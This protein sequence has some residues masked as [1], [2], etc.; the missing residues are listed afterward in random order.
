MKKQI[1]HNFVYEPITFFEN[2]R[3]Y[4]FKEALREDW[5]MTK[6]DIGNTLDAVRDTIENSLIA[7]ACIPVVIYGSAKMIMDVDR[8]VLSRSKS[9]KLETL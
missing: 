3:K 9:Q 7:L 4:G 6:T 8:H 2:A 1:T 5:Y